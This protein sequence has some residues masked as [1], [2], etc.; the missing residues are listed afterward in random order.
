[1]AGNWWCN[2]SF[3]LQHFDQRRIEPDSQAA[4]GG[5]DA[6]FGFDA[7]SDDGR[8]FHV[9]GFARKN[10]ELAKLVERLAPGAPD[11]FRDQESADL[12]GKDRAGRVVLDR[13][14]VHEFGA[15]PVGHDQSVSGGAIVVGRIKSADMQTSV[16]SGGND[17]GFGFDREIFFGFD[18]VEDAAGTRP[19]ASRISSTVGMNSR[20]VILSGLLRTSSMSV[21]MMMAPV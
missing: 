4:A 21:R 15:C 6:V 18:V 1:M 14:H 2:I 3:T 12:F 19:L 13:I 7:F 5:G 8:T 17:G 11:L 20:V 9:P 16:T 10:K